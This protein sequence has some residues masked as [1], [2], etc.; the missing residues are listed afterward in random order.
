I[1]NFR[2]HDG[3]EYPNNWAPPIFW[4][5]LEGVTAAGNCQK[6]SGNPLFVMDSQMAFS[7]V[8]AYQ[9][10]GKE[11]AVYFDD[12]KLNVE[13]AWCRALYITGGDQVPLM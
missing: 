9:L 6:W 2:V 13:G 12:T 7:M 5:T 1:K 10:A 4:F 11:V 3:K 8:L